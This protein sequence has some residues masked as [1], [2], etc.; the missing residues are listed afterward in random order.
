MI[1]S[2]TAAVFLAA[3]SLQ[4]AVY[5]EPAIA[6]QVETIIQY[7]VEA[8]NNQ[9]PQRFRGSGRREVLA[10]NQQ[11]II[12]GYIASMGMNCSQAQADDNGYGFVM[13]PQDVEGYE[14]RRIYV[15]DPLDA[16]SQETAY[17]VA[18]SIVSITTWSPVTV[19][20]SLVEAIR[21]RGCIPLYD[22]YGTEAMIDWVTLPY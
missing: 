20:D 15:E 16:L 19:R 6:P 12:I 4:T 1:L 8:Q 3:A 9:P 5:P 18:A 14:T 11:R 13:V 2:S 21:G 22:T 17:N 7:E 10:Q